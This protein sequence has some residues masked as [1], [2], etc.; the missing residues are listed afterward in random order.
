MHNFTIPINIA[1]NANNI[2]NFFTRV[3]SKYQ[4]Y[5][6]K[7]FNNNTTNRYNTTTAA[8]TWRFLTGL[9]KFLG[10]IYD[11]FLKFGEMHRPKPWRNVLFSYLL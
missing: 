11:E 1:N 9:C 2:T 10:N 3:N 5:Y 4:R 6:K 7:K 8:N